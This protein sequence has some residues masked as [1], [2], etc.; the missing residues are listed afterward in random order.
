[1]RKHFV[2][3]AVRCNAKLL[4]LLVFLRPADFVGGRAAD[5]YNLRS[6]CAVQQGVDV[7]FTLQYMSDE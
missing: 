2:V 6:R 1:M 4:V 5:G 7:A 3:V